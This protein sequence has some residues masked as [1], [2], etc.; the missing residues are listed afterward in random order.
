MPIIYKHNLK[1][2]ASNKRIA[3]EPSTKSVYRYNNV[4]TI[5]KEG[6]GVNSGAEI[7]SGISDNIG[8]ME[9]EYC[10]V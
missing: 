7:S 3:H 6:D 2:F 8:G 10:L 5:Q 1:H 9:L 4:E